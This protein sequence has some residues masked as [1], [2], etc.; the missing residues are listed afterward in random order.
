MTAIAT[1]LR[2][3]AIAAL[4][5]A[6]VG[7]AT[8]AS[9][10]DAEAQYRRGHRGAAVAAGVIGGLAA[11]ALIAGATRPAY[12]YGYGYDHG[13]SRPAYGYNSYDRGYGYAPAYGVRRV[14]V[15]PDCHW[16]RQRVWIDR[17]TYTTRRVRVCN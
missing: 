4:A 11:G 9:V 5:L 14:Y 15:E 13:Y 16:Q 7:G 10:Q 17:Y 12:G 3:P 6:T 8:L 1:R 2:V